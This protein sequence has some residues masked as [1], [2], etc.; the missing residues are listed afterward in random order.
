LILKQAKQSD[1]VERVTKGAI[2]AEAASAVARFQREQHGRGANDIRAHLVGDMLVVRSGGIWTPT[3][4]RLAASPEGRRLIQSARREL[5]SIHRPEIE[6]IVAGIVGVA[7]LR[8]YYDVH[9]EDAE[10]VEVYM[11]AADVDKKLLRQDVERLNSLTPRR[12]G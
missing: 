4:T 3:E 10:Q 1:G 11:L 8:S 2:E 5:R 9:V 7:V 6:G 12:A